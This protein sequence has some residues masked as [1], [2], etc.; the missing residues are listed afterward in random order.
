[1]APHGHAFRAYRFPRRK[2]A[3]L[4]RRP[5]AVGR[6]GPIASGLGAFM[7]AMLAMGGVAAAAVFGYFAADL[8]E[9]HDLATVPVPLTTHIYDRSGEH[10]LYTLEE[11]RRELISL[12]Q[13]PKLM[14][15]A[16]VSI[17]NI[18]R[19]LE[20]GKPLSDAIVDGAEQIAV[21]AFVSMLSICLV[22][23]PI[24]ALSGPAA[25]LFRWRYR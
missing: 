14:Q 20:H 2:G 10:L 13:I 1:M 21:P 12:D 16:T 23:L 7:L 19:N 11:E 5:G 9:A 24:F 17:E 6:L 8:P 25:A 15:D 22:F 18:H 4:S 3:R